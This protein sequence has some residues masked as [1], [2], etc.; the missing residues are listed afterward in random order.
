PNLPGDTRNF[1]NVSTTQSQ[2][3]NISLRVTHNFTPAAAGGGRG[4]GG[5]GGGGFAG[6]QRGGARGGRGAAQQGTAVNMTAALQYRRS[7]NQTQ[8]VLPALGGR[9]T[10]TSLGVPVSFNIRHKRTMHTVNVNFS[11]TSATTLN[12]YAGVEDVAGNAG[13]AGVSTDPLNWGVPSLSFSSLSSVRDLTPSKR[14]DRRVTLAYNW[15]RPVRT[16]QIRF[17]GDYRFDR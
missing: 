14:S 8:N 5:R 1:H 4:G 16:H 10:N 9:G 2:A 11:S 3:D 6:G 15:T 7:E 12:H 13:I 17:G